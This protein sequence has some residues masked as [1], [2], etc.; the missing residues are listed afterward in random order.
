MLKESSRDATYNK[1]DMLKLMTLSRETD[2]REGV[3][4]RQSKGWFQVAAIGHE[5]LAAVGA[6]LGDEDYIFGYYRERPMVL[7]KGVPSADLASAFFA[8]RRSSSGGRQMPGHHS[9]REKN[10]WSI[11]TPT[12]SVLLPGCGAAWAMQLE[13]KDGVVIG[14]VGDAAS[15]E[16][17]FYEAICFAVQE[18]LPMVFIIEDNRYG[19]STCTD[20]VNPFN[21]NIFGDGV[22]IVEVDARHPDN[23][24]E[25]AAP[26]IDK[27]RR[28]DGPTVLV[29]KMDR[30]CDHTSSDDQRIYRSAEE[31]AEMATRDPIDVVSA[32]LIA[33][34]AMTAEEW[35]ATR[36]EIKA[37]VNREYQAAQSEEDPKAEEV[38]DE[39]FGPLP[40][41][42]TPPLEGGRKWRI[43]DAINTVFQAA[44]EKDDRYVF[45]GQDIADPKG[46]VFGLTK[47]LST[48][49]PDRVFN[50][51]LS[52]ATIVGTACGMAGYG[53][54]PVFEI[55]FVD[56]IGPAWNQFS[57][58]MATIRWRTMGD[59]KCPAV[60]Y[61][62]Y[63]AYLPGGSLWHSQANESLFAHTPGLRVV[64]PSTPEDAAGLMWTALHAED[65]TIYL[66]PKHRFRQ[67]FDVPEVVEPVPFGSAAIRR[68]GEDVTLVAWGNCIEQ[69]Y[70]AADQLGDEV[71]VEIIDLRT[72]VPWDRETVRA[73][74]E[75]TGR[76]VIVQEDNESCS[77]G[78]MIITEVTGDP[79]TWDTFMSPPQLVARPDVHIGFNPIYEYAALPST[80]QVVA[81]IRLTM[82]E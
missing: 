49:H 3:L 80:D 47:G 82:E 18:K 59:W 61:A 9:S 25:A 40:V 45:F 71:S 41:A 29:C 17:E 20:D 22:D 7:A 66:V 77:V 42:E 14:T 43:V 48:K 15:R 32:E 1:L 63:G 33:A 28:G 38:M 73:S 56:F 51:P 72:I 31:I 50:A 4:L 44:L 54:K 81:A 13:G 69:A 10:I 60:I 6:L 21:M 79:D 46:G 36:A 34:G 62:P 57:Q 11:P 12:G 52:E 2:V 55:Q 58:N 30:I 23:V 19:I 27:A 37:Q 64:V 67:Q 76:L 75:K 26:A 78:Q 24:H 70:A 65:P 16:G 5:A 68:E 74:L 53:M 8:K 35:E 39:L